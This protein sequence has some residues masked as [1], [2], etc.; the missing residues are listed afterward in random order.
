MRFLVFFIIVN[1]FPYHRT[2][3]TPRLE[4]SRE[5]YKVIYGGKSE[6]VEP[7]KTRILKREK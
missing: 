6:V 1:R 5:E 3:W 7:L 2:V 4:Y